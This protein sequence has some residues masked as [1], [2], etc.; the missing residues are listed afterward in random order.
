MLDAL[1]HDLAQSPATVITTF[2]E[3]RNAHPEHE[4]LRAT[5]VDMTVDDSD[6]EVPGPL[7]GNRF[8]S[9]YDHHSEDLNSQ[10][11]ACFEVQRLG[12][13]AS[14]SHQ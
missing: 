13:D 12:E 1:E 14:T 11:T 8:A 9:L 3:V 2:G 4:S 10:K 7:R 5:V 6:H